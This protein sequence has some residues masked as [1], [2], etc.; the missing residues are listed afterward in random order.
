MREALAV[1][2]VDGLVAAYFSPDGPFAGTSFDLVGENPPGV[3][4]LDD[5]L[6]TMLL[7][8][9]W[10][11]LAI[12][13]LIADDNGSSAWLAQVTIWLSGEADLDTVRLADDRIVNK[14]YELTG[15]DDL[16]VTLDEFI[17]LLI[18]ARIPGAAFVAQWPATTA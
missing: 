5:L 6:A 12:R 15:H 8:I 14:H 13:A 3:L 11:P 4:T 16:E 9:S 17:G 7:N 2:G 10:R 18:G 1:P